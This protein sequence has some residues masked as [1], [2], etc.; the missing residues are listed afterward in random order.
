MFFPKRIKSATAKTLKSSLK[1]DFNNL[2]SN[3]LKQKNLQKAGNSLMSSFGFEKHAYDK[4]IYRAICSVNGMLVALLVA[5]GVYSITDT[6][7]E[8]SI[9]KEKLNNIVGCVKYQNKLV[10][11]AT[12]GTCCTED[13]LKASRI[14]TQYFPSLA[15]C[16]DRIFGVS[17]KDL[18]MTDAGDISAW[19]NNLTINAHT[20]LDAV[21]ALDK[22]Y[23]LG[24]T[25]YSLTPNAE[26]INMKFVPFCF[27][28]GAVQAD[29]VV[30]FEK[31][32]VFASTNGLYMLTSNTVTPIFTKLNDYI[33]FDGCVACLHNGKY[34]V[35]CKRKDGD[36]TNDILLVLD[37]DSEKIVS[38]LDVKAQHISSIDG[39]LYAVINNKLYFASDIDVESSYVDTVDFGCSNVK[40]LDK[41]VIRT[42]TDVDVW[43]D[44]GVEKRRYRV[45]GKNS[46]QS[47]PLTGSGRQFTVEVQA[48]NGLKLD[49]VE[50]TARTYEV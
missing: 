6:Y 37:T 7:S 5:N 41:L 26:E 48:R 38:V 16:Y 31:Y 24:D 46:I 28:I 25:C 22:L 9:T 20:P 47:V 33:I 27:G 11:S 17:G 12:Y 23:V 30:A 34:F 32:A 40:Y 43:I 39:K 21:V 2:G 10:V 19:D 4:E 44:N 8:F 49:C 45:L 18:Y 50:L 1:I 13:G 36:M 15:V 3:F 29:S 42:K 14:T 35:T